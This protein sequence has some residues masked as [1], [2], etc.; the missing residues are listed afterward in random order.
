Q[1]TRND[2][3]SSR[4]YLDREPE[5]ADA[6][7]SAMSAPQKRFAGHGEDAGYRECVQP[8]FQRPRHRRSHYTS[9]SA[10]TRFLIAGFGVRRARALDQQIAAEKPERRAP[11]WD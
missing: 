1:Q 8:Q 2:V 4:I 3:K 11:S 9:P 10:Q 6:N 5:N 7:P